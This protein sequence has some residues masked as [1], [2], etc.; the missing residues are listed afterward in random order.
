[1][2]F[3]LAT[4][5]AISL[6]STCSRTAMPRMYAIPREYA[7]IACHECIQKDVPLWIYARLINKESR[8]NKNCISKNGNGT[9][10]L[11]I[12]QL[13]SAYLPDFQ[14]FDNSG[15]PFDP[16]NPDEAIPVSIRYLA[17]LHRAFKSWPLAIAAYNCG[18]GAVSRGCIPASTAKYVF[19]IVGKDKAGL[20]AF[21][22]RCDEK[23]NS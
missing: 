16:F 3:S 2:I 14:W 15:V 10:D 13:N 23:P 8:W 19:D 6:W 21:V 12:A 9:K 18:P 4:F 17:R 1:M 20:E 11:G 5:V 22:D 7:A